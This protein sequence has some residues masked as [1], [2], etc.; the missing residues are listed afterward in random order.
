[1]NIC[2]YVLMMAGADFVG[3]GPAA[4]TASGRHSVTGVPR[5]AQAGFLRL[6]EM[7]REAARREERQHCP[8]EGG[9]DA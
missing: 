1:M 7:L 8:D 2:L 9:G 4:H 6:R 5:A 3:P